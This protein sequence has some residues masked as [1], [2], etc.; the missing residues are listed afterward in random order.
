MPAPAVRRRRNRG[1]DHRFLPALAGIVDSATADA[2]GPVVVRVEG[3]VQPDVNLGLL[4][5]E[6]GT[7][8]FTELAGFEA[9]DDWTVFGLR[10]SGRSRRLDEPD[11]EPRRTSTVY[12]LD[13]RGREASLIRHGEE[14][15]DAP[16]R[17][18]G[19]IPDLCRRVL[20]LPTA[21]PPPTTAVL[22]SAVWLDRIVDR[23][24]QPHRRQDLASFAQLA[25]LHPAVHA[26]SPPDLLAVADPASLARVARP[27]AASTTWEQ[28]RLARE[29]LPLPDGALDRSIAQWMDNGFFA[30]W[31]IGAH[32]P[33]A[34]TALTLLD[35]LGE[36]HGRALVEALALLLEP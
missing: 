3:P 8:P 29:P 34:A 4:P 33:I 25:I 2:A 24:A 30:R 28:V 13:R 11:E 31:T 5:L 18:T 7:H 35:V 32:P 22:W 9:P 12:L 17:A 16:G 1:P 21:P 36:R 26:P 6:E 27:H 20:Q 10:V 19:T 14:V 15:I 23:W